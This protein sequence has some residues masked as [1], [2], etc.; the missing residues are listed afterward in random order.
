MARYASV[1]WACRAQQE[2]LQVRT[3]SQVPWTHQDVSANASREVPRTLQRVTESLKLEGTAGRHLVQPPCSGRAA[4]S[5]LPRTMAKQLLNISKNG[6]ST[7]SLGNLCQ[8]LVTLTLKKVFPDVKRESS[9][10]QCVPIASGPGTG[11]H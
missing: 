5:W 11:H 8:C 9:V 3:S 7:T 4:E 6:E 2:Q 1:L 10:F